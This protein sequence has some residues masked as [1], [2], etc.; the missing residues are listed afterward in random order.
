METLDLMDIK[1]IVRINYLANSI[2]ELIKNKE[3]M[4]QSDYQGAIDAIIID[5]MQFGYRQK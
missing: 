4:T 3:E 2:E 1:V 5:A